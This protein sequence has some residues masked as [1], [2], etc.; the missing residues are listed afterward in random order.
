MRC[1]HH[2]PQRIH[3]NSVIEEVGDRLLRHVGERF[4]RFIGSGHK[5]EADEHELPAA[6]G[7]NASA[8]EA[9]RR[10]LIEAENTGYIQT[11]D[12]DTLIEQARKHDL[13]LRLQYQPGDFAH[14][15]YF[16][17]ESML[18]NAARKC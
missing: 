17:T 9:S 4:P 18:A 7:R 16:S 3:I 14:V 5:D 11:I 13:V 8:D 2:V 6:F 10:R 12:D 1:I 15:G